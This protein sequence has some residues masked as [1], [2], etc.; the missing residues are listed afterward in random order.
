M[1]NQEK[2]LEMLDFNQPSSNGV[3]VF[4]AVCRTAITHCSWARK[5]FKLVELVEG[6]LAYLERYCQQ[7]FG[8]K[9]NSAPDPIPADKTATEAAAGTAVKPSPKQPEPA[10]VEPEAA[11][12]IKAS[13]PAEEVADEPIDPHDKGEKRKVMMPDSI[14]DRVIEGVEASKDFA[15]NPPKDPVQE[16][17]L[18]SS[19]EEY[20]NVF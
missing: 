4:F 6:Q 5:D 17:P 13:T 2:K 18:P 7:Q 1:D 14:L 8:T 3:G 19:E 15:A 16:A 20:D 12:T 10:K 11:E 9:T